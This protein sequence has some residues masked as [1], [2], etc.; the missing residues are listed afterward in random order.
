MDQL[1]VRCMCCRGRE[2][3][4]VENVEGKAMIIELSDKKTTSINSS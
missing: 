2:G 3:K 4:V 1:T